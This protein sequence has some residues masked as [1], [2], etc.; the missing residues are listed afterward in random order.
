MQYR[1]TYR[2][3]NVIC[4]ICCPG[5]VRG[6]VAANRNYSEEQ[7]NA[8]VYARHAQ[9]SQLRSPPRPAEPLDDQG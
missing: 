5:G 3:G 7:R 2:I 1:V 4:V 8:E 6:I 9:A